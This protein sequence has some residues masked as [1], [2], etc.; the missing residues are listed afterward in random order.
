MSQPPI[1]IATAGHVDHGKSTLVKTLTGIDPDRWAQEKQR[2][3]TIDL[4]YA[5]MSHEGRSYSFIDVPGHE[6]FIH[7]MLAGV[8]AIDA[9][10]FVIAADESIMPQTREHARALAYL[11]VSQV[12]VVLSKIDLIDEELL[13]LLTEEVEEWLIE[14]GWQHAEQVHFS[15]KQEQTHQAM[16]RVLAS[17]VKQ[18]PAQGES[19]RLTIDR[20]FTS[21][22]SG[23]VITG[24]ADRG[25]LKASELLYIQ[26]LGITARTRQLQVHRENVE[27]VTA[28]TR[29]AINISD[30]HYKELARGHTVFSKVRPS[31][32]RKLLVRLT[33]F[34]KEWAPGPRH[35][36]HL[37]HLAAHSQAR[38]LWHCQGFAM[39]ELAQPHPFWALDRGLIRDGSPLRVLAGFEVLD[40]LPRRSR[41]RDVQASLMNPP[42]AGELESWQSWYLDSA[43]GLLS[44]TA[45]EQRCGEPLSSQQEMVIVSKTRM[46]RTTL[47]QQYSDTFQAELKA[48][49]KKQPLFER[50]PRTLFL[51]QLSGLGWPVELINKLLERAVAEGH[52][53][54]YGDRLKF[55]KHR[56]IWKPADLELMRKLLMLLQRA[57]AVIDFK[58]NKEDQDRFAA[59]QDLLIWEKYVIP[60]SPD[61]LI[62]YRFLNQIM[63]TLHH[64]YSN[65]IFSIQQL[66]QEF[67]FSRKYAIPLLEYLD[68]IGCTRREQEGRIWIALEPPLIHCDWQ[69][70]I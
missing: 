34:E 55:A 69:P 70:P 61:L 63:E 53:Q 2:G 39:L 5:H 23:T 19:F 11:G 40:P 13:G 33:C 60:L 42:A 20:V 59:L 64:N 38:A 36:F 24:T 68:K 47:W 8:G 10:L 50:I 35:R 6:K 27:K 65:K 57:P 12:K 4:G 62:S 21:P 17:L 7:N 3:I 54:L 15:T 14:F 30:V 51:N 46:I 26:P 37:H 16:K 43:A 44:T 48:C 29:I 18:E 28:H 66:K 1:L 58:A 9:V 67:S 52:V 22:G 45:I 32:T 49:H 25:S 31:C 56:V 41:W